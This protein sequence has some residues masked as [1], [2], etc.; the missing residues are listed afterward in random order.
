LWNHLPELRYVQFPW[1]WLLCLNVPFALLI[2][3]AVR[4]WPLRIVVCAAALAS[5]VLVWRYVQPPW[6]D[7][8]SDIQEMVE[9]QHEGI[10]N[11]GVDEYVPANV[12]PYDAD[13][14]A[15]RVRFEG[16]GQHQ[17]QTPRWDAESRTI[18]ATTA[19]SGNLILRLF[20]YPDWR[21]TVNGA[22]IN[23]L[24]SQT[25]QMTIPLSAGQSKV[26]ISFAEGWDR[27][28]GAGISLVSALIGLTVPRKKSHPTP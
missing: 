7:Q 17:I 28:V 19:V 21:V 13:Q 16:P 24:T 8:A 14:N 27:W 2:A 15:P 11:E 20:N 10:G 12:D 26:E 1:R 3:L 25:G 5:V 4:R 6:W 18:L 9:N 22:R 23:T